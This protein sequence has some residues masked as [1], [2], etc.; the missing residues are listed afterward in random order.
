MEAV[1][2]VVGWYSA[3]RLAARLGGKTLHVP[4]RMD[5]GHLIALIVGPDKA[6]EISDMMGGE[7]IEL[8]STC[9]IQQ[10]MERSRLHDNICEMAARGVETKT[11]ARWLHMSRKTVQKV[12]DQ[13]QAIVDAYKAKHPRRQE[14]QK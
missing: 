9:E 14:V 7:N 5:E 4:E 13:Q 3:A 2:E 10:E 6:K 8:P 11:I 12:L 1:A